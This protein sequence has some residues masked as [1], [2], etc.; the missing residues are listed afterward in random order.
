MKRNKVLLLMRMM[1]INKKSREETEG[2]RERVL[3]ITFIFADS[4]PRYLFD[5]CA[6]LKKIGM[7]T[8]NSSYWTF[9]SS[10]KNCAFPS[11][12]LFF[13]L[14]VENKMALELEEHTEKW[15]RKFIESYSFFS[16]LFVPLLSLGSILVTWK[17]LQ[18]FK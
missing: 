5:W 11:T 14:N 12:K 2:E 16:C 15:Q 18:R 1:M 7:I 4:Y 6:E 8:M 3:N 13:L 9:Y 10:L 17:I